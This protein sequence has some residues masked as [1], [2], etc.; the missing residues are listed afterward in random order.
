MA[1][2]GV[3]LAVAAWLVASLIPGSGVSAQTNNEWQTIEPGGDTLCAH[4][5]PYRF[6]ARE[7]STDRLLIYFQDGGACWDSSTCGAM[8]F[9]PTV[10]EDQDSPAYRAAGIFDLANPE[11]P[12]RDDDMVYITYC[13]GDAHLGSSEITYVGD[14]ALV[15]TFHNGYVNAQAALAWAF[16]A[17]PQPDSI[18]VVGCSAGGLGAIF[19]T[20]SII[21]HYECVPVVQ[22]SDGA[23]GF[24]NTSASL[25]RAWGI[26]DVLP[27]RIASLEHSTIYD[28]S[29]EWMYTN[30]VK[31]YPEARFAQA[32][33]AHD[34]V[35][36]LFLGLSAA[37]CTYGE[38][39]AANLADISAA[40]P[41]F[42]YYTAWGTSHC[43]TDVAGFYTYQVNGVRFRDWM[44][45]LVNGGDIANVAC[46]DC[47][48]PEYYAP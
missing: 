5:T 8:T 43:L 24:R 6:F 17:F 9:D 44:A 13:T 23:G 39:L 47:T 41:D 12:F 4:G 46:T 1:H 32:N 26:D 31:A 38:G 29:F 37:S 33:T 25:M 14:A 40:N 7:G 11:N 18:V 48:T 28:L 15:D 35:Q 27:G 42:R 21:E 19:H 36:T 3:L 34:S 22:L 16:E 45:D 30:I 10:N 20:P 2:R